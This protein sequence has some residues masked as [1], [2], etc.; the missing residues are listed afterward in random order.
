MDKPTFNYT[1]KS[2]KSIDGNGYL[3]YVAEVPGAASFAANLDELR[4]NLIDAVRT[5][6]EHNRLKD[7]D[8]V[9]E[10]EYDESPLCA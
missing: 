3:G 6:H 1:I 7:A 2:K 4:E 9:E 8:K 10:G 5:V